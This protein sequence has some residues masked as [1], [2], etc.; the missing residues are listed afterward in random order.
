MAAMEAG[1]SNLAASHSRAAATHTIDIPHGLQ[2]P[3]KRALAVVALSLAALRFFP[4]TSAIYTH[5][6]VYLFRY[7]AFLNFHNFMLLHSLTFALFSGN[8]YAKSNDLTC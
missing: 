2:H 8:H 1:S 5:L 3:R 4:Y 6:L 7:C